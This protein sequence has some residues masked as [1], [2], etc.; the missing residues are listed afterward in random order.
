MLQVGFE[1]LGF[2][3]RL[4][5]AVNTAVCGGKCIIEQEGVL[6]HLTLQRFKVR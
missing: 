5:G 6:I 4:D 2:A 3:P 1:L